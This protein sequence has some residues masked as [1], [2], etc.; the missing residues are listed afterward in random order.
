MGDREW[1]PRRA[2]LRVLEG[3]HMETTDLSFGQGWAN[4]ERASE[5]V[6]QAILAEAPPPVSP[7]AF[8]IETDDP[9]ALLGAVLAEHDGRAVAV[10]RGERADRRPRPGGRGR[11][12]RAQAEGLSAQAAGTGAPKESAV[13]RGRTITG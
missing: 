12:P 10:A 8:V 11:D 3:P 7:D 1:E 9:E 4:A 13:P 5:D 2:S 6:T